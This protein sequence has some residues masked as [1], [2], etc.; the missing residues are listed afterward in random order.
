MKA[1]G[2]DIGTTTICCIA[3]D[4]QTGDII[5][6]DTIP[7]DSFIEDCKI[8]EK[9]QDPEK[10]IK[11]VLD[12][13]EDYYHKFEK[14][15]AIGITGQMHGILYLDK[16]GNSV[17]PL[18]TWQ[19]KRGDTYSG[20]KTYTEIFSETTNSNAA[21]GYGLVTH[22]YNV[23]NNIVPKS[24][25]QISTIHDYAAMRLCGL[26]KAITHISDAA[27]LGAFN[28]KENNFN[29]DA[30]NKLGIKNEILPEVT[31]NSKIVGKYK[32]IPVAVAIGDN[33]ASFIGSV[34]DEDMLL[35]NIGTGSQVSVIADTDTM[36]GD[37][38]IRPLYGNKRISVGAC[39]CGG[40]A[41]NNL[42]DFFKKVGKQLFNVE[43]DRLYSA[44]DAL[45]ST[46]NTLTVDT[47]FSGTRKS[48]EIRGSIN[49]IDTNNFTP[50]ALITGTLEGMV[51]EL[52]NLY[53]QMKSVASKPSKLII[54]SG[55]G[56]RLN[57]PIRR[58]IEERFRMKILIPKHREEAAFGAVIF[59]LVAS[60]EY[61]SIKEAQ[62]A[63]IK[64][65]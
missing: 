53:D 49:G 9:L 13:A 2:I 54:G 51:D 42:F 62:N 34:K 29:T 44:M 59:S 47:R 18:Y 14:I 21:T 11:K 43:N 3:V 50:A 23:K 52:E 30:L 8:F 39:L 63:L 27:S 5:K 15:V 65:E 36:K 22:F 61:S 56:I 31:D 40:R 12:L 10:I 48:P 57:K 35:I 28:M 1:I 6:S 41:Y 33:Q 64:Y 17:S 46:K 7:N 45:V 37:C 24:A 55:N 58:I 4:V 16:N 32:E 26:N 25:T 38:E 20:E 60:G 19:D